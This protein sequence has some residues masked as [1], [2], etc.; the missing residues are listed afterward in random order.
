MVWGHSSYMAFL[1]TKPLEESVCIGCLCLNTQMS[2]TVLLIANIFQNLWIYPWSVVYQLSSRVLD[3]KI[4]HPHLLRSH[5]RAMSRAREFGFF[6]FF[7]HASFV[8]YYRLLPLIL[9]HVLFELLQRSD[10]SFSIEV[11]ACSLSFH[12][13]LLKILSP[14]FCWTYCF[15]FYK[16]LCR[17]SVNCFFSTIP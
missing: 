7:F 2:F 14:F 17:A 13:R 16:N 11:L 3:D 15:L 5:E 1:G 10:P 12:W 9:I 4:F 6:T 8:N